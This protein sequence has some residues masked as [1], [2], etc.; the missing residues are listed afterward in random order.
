MSFILK[1]HFSYF[2]EISVFGVESCPY[3]LPFLRTAAWKIHL[4]TRPKAITLA[5]CSSKKL[6]NTN[7]VLPKC[8][9]WNSLSN[10][11]RIQRDWKRRVT[12]MEPIC[13][14]KKIYF[15]LFKFS[16]A[17]VRHRF[18]CYLNFT[19]ATFESATKQ[20]FTACV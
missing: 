10:R 19:T 20:S 16:R 3:Y 11:N 6:V 13:V 4:F 15:K 7:E 5:N 18:Q 12:M 2:F 17:I 14:L 8:K 1:N 9:N